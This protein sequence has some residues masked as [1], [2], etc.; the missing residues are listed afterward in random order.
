MRLYSY[1]RSTAA[2]RVRVA[3]NLKGVDYEIASVDLAKDGGEQHAPDYAV[4]NPAHLVPTLVLDDG[5]ALTQS[6]AVIDWLDAAR[7][8]PPLLPVDPL[9]RARVLSAAHLV[10]MDIH[11]VNNLRVVQELGR[12]F[13]ATGEDRADWMRHWMRIGFDALDHMV[14]PATPF[15]FSDAPTLADICIV[16]QLYNARRWGLD[17]APWPRLAIIDAAARALP[18]FA[19]AAPEMQPDAPSP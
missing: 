10:A 8:E 2:Y 19:D 16:A 9:L 11:P 3:L 17:L 14:D 7:P 6:L 12:R 13:D 5:T 15:A 4:L 18:A 1:W